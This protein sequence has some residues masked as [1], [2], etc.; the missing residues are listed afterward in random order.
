MIKSLIKV[1][2]KIPLSLGLI[3]CLVN[4]KVISPTLGSAVIVCY[5]HGEFELP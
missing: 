3:K 4:F 2:L 1:N 5:L